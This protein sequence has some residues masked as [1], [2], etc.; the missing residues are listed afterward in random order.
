LS[1]SALAIK[2]FNDE[3][4]KARISELE[5]GKVANPAQE[6]VDALTVALNLPPDSVSECRTK[7]RQRTGVLTFEQHEKNMRDRV[8]EAEAKVQAATD[9]ERAVLEQQLNEAQKRAADLEVDF[10]RKQAELDSAH[11]R[12]SR[13]HNEM[14]AD[15]IEIAKKALDEGDTEMADALFEELQQNLSAQGYEMAA[16]AAKLAYERGRIAE[17]DIRWRDADQHYSEAARLAPTYENLLK[18][19]EL[20]RRCGDYRR[21]VRYEEQLVELAEADFG[22]EDIRTA[23]ALNNLAESY[24]AQGR[25]DEAEPLCRRAIEIGEKTLGLGHPHIASYINNL[26]G[27]LQATGRSDEAEPLYRRAIEIGEKTLGPDHPDVANWANNFATLLQATGRY[28]EAEHLY[29]YA[30]EIG[31]KILSAE[32][33]Y[34]AGWMSNLASLLS[35]TARRDE[36][37]ELLRRALSIGEKTLGND[38]PDVATWRDNL[39]KFL[40]DSGRLAKERA[41]LDDNRGSVATD[42]KHVP[43]PT[44]ESARKQTLEAGVSPEPAIRDNKIDVRPNQ[45]IDQP[46][47][48]HDFAELPVR[49]TSIIDG[50]LEDV[51]AGGNIPV[52]CIAAL[53]RYRAELLARGPHPML[54]LLTDQHQIVRD[55]YLALTREKFFGDPPGGGLRRSFL[56]FTKNHKS[57][58]AHYPKDRVPEEN[59]AAINVRYDDINIE[60]LEK[61]VADVSLS[62]DDLH[63]EQGASDTFKDVAGIIGA[64]AVAAVRRIPSLAMQQNRKLLGDPDEQ[65]SVKRSIVKAAVFAGASAAVLGSGAS[66]AGYVA[67]GSAPKL[68]QAF[69]ELAK[70]L[71]SFIW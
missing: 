64:D 59:L 63:E 27:L 29:R 68:M 9:A 34:V 25:F 5:R 69:S 70:Y 39:A 14:E 24:R 8:A 17:D 56:S 36:A 51:G 6:I 2:A 22:P 71:G 26:G 61:L 60:I 52:I 58:V 15:K 11:E 44:G 43:E 31:R 38:H 21:S 53:K 57:L 54:G 30:L 65:S 4:R 35:A 49:Q 23:T 18:A 45:T 46:I 13:F 41:N 48:S 62:V 3:S 7:G 19:G 12:L 20:A 47:G 50:I 42:E 32:H 66:I 16:E 37:E 1:Q 28:D 55:E 10:A 67:P 33:P 40:K